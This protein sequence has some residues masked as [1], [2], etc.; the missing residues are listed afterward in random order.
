MFQNY[1]PFSIQPQLLS[2][3]FVLVVLVTC[4]LIYYIKLRKTKVNE[5]PYGYVL[6]VQIY[7]EY[8]RNL[9]VE[10]LGKRFEKITPYF[11]FLLSYLALSNVVGI[12]GLENPTS[13]LTVTLTLGL[14]MF[15]GNFAIGFRYQKLSYL[16]RYTFN[17]K[18]KKTG[19][20]YGIFP[21]PLEMVGLVS[22]LISISFRLWG[23]M[24][25]GTIVIGL[26]FYAMGMIF[27]SIPY[28]GVLNLLGGLTAPPLH[29]YFDFLAGII[30]ALVFTLLTMIYWTVSKEHG[31][32]EIKNN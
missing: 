28:I 11:I 4:V 2:I 21:N 8:I 17:I 30:Q 1:S 9:V 13:S 27:Y 6:L 26:W 10:I 20:H 24:F 5:A 25:A 7:V 14:V 3:A 23:N 32:Y 19:K 12:I 31:N 15:I 22:P 16:T 18:S 29:A